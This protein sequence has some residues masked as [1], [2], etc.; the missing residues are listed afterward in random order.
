MDDSRRATRRKVWTAAEVAEL[1][2][3]YPDTPTATLAERFG[4]PKY[5]VYSKAKRLGLMKSAEF[6]RLHCRRL[7][8]VIGTSTRF[9]KG[10][11]PHNKGKAFPTRGRAGETQFKPGQKP[12]TWMPIG[13]ER[14]ADGYLYRKVSDCHP[15]GM[16]RFDWKMVH[17][18]NWEAVHGPV[19]AGH[20][21]CFRD[22]DRKNT[23]IDNLHLVSRRE[24][25]ARNTVHN[26]PK[27]LAQVVQLR[28]Q[29]V[30]QIN[31][32]SKRA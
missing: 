22:G 31:R 13:S 18:I 6:L 5:A 20:A 12:R 17:I 1:H 10:L 24:L 7:D 19:P 14:V 16:S 23:G 8:G 28:A 2:A 26:L 27:E 32:R 21:V 11:V 15:P 3:M 30:R 29:V 9:A 4:C 25:M